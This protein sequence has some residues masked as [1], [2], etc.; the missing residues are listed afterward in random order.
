[1]QLCSGIISQCRLKFVGIRGMDAYVGYIF[2]SYKDSIINGLEE[3]NKN[4]RTRVARTN[5]IHK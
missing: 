4:E 2:P 5:A 1:M 3:W